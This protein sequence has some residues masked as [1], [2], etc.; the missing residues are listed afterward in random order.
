MP[1]VQPY[2]LSGGMSHSQVF[3]SGDCKYWQ[4]VDI[5]VALRSLEDISYGA[6]FSGK[7]RQ[8]DGLLE[9][10]KYGLIHK[11]KTRS[12]QPDLDQRTIVLVAWTIL[13]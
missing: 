5:I 4:S 7:L 11:Y 9:K 6:S 1:M 2:L 13:N 12:A 10:S 3:V 8:P